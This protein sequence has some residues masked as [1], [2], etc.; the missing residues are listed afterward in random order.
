MS[1]AVGACAN[2]DTSYEPANLLREI[3][4]LNVMTYNL[5]GGT[6]ENRTANPGNYWD[7]SSRYN[8]ISCLNHWIR[9]GTPH[10]KMIVGI[11]THSRNFQLDN[12]EN[13]GIF[14]SAIF[15]GFGQPGELPSS[16]SYNVICKNIL[17]NGWTRKYDYTDSTGPY[18]YFGTTW[19]GYDDLESIREKAFLVKK[20]NFGGIVFWSLDHDDH[21]NV[22]GDGKFPLIRSV[23]DVI[24]T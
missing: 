17:E 3:D 19:A 8:V 6:W 15:K 21:S 23:W 13:N 11:P 1:A 22:C 2:L 9:K 24:M 7:K 14:A 12:P 16:Y 10:N 20:V 4:F 5:H 18:A